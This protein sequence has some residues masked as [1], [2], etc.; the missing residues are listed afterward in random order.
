ML[1]NWAQSSNV[2]Q[3]NF[4]VSLEIVKRGKSFTDDE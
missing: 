3:T 2:N 1:N 4:A